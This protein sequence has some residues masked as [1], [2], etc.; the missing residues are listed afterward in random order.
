MRRCRPRGRAVGGPRRSGRAALA[1]ASL[2]AVV[3][4]CVAGLGA[5]LA[6]VRCADAARE[7]AR[8]AARGDPAA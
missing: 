3:L 8:L 6:G 4:V 1:I 5:I 7:A 2:V